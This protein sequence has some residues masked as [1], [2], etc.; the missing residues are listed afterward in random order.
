MPGTTS[1]RPAPAP[2]ARSQT[3]A[4]QLVDRVVHG[5]RREGHVGERGIHARRAGHAGAIGDEQV[6]HVVGLVVSVEDGGLRVLPHARRPH[7][8]YAEPRRAVVVPRLDV[9]ASR[10]LE[11]LGGLGLHVLPDGALVLTP[12]T[13]DAEQR[14]PPPVRLRRAEVQEV[15]VARQALTVSL[16][17]DLPPPR[18]AQPLLQLD[19]EPRLLS[20][21]G[22][23]F[24][25]RARLDPVPA[26]EPDLR[27]A[28]PAQVAEARDVRPRG[29]PR[30]A[31]RVFESRNG[32]AS[33]LRG[34]RVPC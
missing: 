30:V 16:Q 6:R 25:A 29:P 32:P 8:V 2:R 27:L 20:P 19:A 31:V 10:R 5:A 17:V 3:L 15:L 11:H 13:V 1:P 26:H 22:P 7:L 24:A 14:D 33:A 21:A 34:A 23:S 12:R 18:L 28:G 9:P 4:L